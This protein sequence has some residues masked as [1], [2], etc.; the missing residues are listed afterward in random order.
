MKPKAEKGSYFGSLLQRSG[1]TN[2]CLVAG[3]FVVYFLS[4]PYPQL[5][6]N[7]TF[8]IAE[9]FLHGRIGLVERP[10][11]WLNEMIPF[12]G[13][14]YSAFPLGGVLTMLPFSFLKLIGL[15]TDMPSSLIVALT[16]A[17]IS[18]FL[19]LIG[20]KYQHTLPKKILMA[21]GIL[22]GTFL[23]ANLAMGS[24]WQMA[25]G[26]AMIGELGAIYFT[27]YDRRPLL[28][29]LFFALAFGNRT[30][31][32]LTAPIFLYLLTRDKAKL[33]QPSSYAGQWKP[34][35]FFC[36][37]PFILGIATL[38]YNYLRFHSFTDFGYARIP[39]VLKEPWYRYGIFSLDYIS[40]NVKEMLFTLWSRVPRFPYLKP[41]GFGGAVWLSSPF[42][43][44]LFRFGAKDKLI[45]Y[46][47][48]VAIA[49]MVFLLWCHG[50]PG[51]YQFSY[52]YAIIL[53]P[54]VYVIL[55]ESS[56]KKITPLEWVLYIFSFIANLFATYL[57]HWTEYM[58][59]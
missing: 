36:L 4:N 16:A 9:N 54:W 58:K 32:I 19:I 43:F 39:G 44:L 49:L 25:L 29:G 52:R 6:Y 48:W 28:A 33:K 20:K 45:K 26:F 13:L 40:F 2:L 3:T 27:I 5:Y 47:A 10:P 17:V 53:L 34:I 11:S 1:W 41:T 15:I 8:L 12:E 24:A 18:I 23:W 22:F 37:V 14:Y 31:I 46:T 21:A 59:M 57:F 42:L 56:P 7:Y 30:E 55:L 50:N 38:L 35:V 51:G